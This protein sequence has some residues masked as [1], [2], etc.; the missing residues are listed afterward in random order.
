MTKAYP[1]PIE[2]NVMSSFPGNQSGPS[3]VISLSQIVRTIR[4]NL[5]LLMFVVVTIFSII[6]F[7]T[8]Q[9][10]PIYQASA[11]VI[12][13]QRENAVLD[14]GVL[15]GLPA[16]PGVFETELEI[17][18]SPVLLQRVVRKLELQQ[19]AEFNP[20]LYVP[21]PMEEFQAQVRGVISSLIPK[22]EEEVVK[23]EK[24]LTEE[25]KAEAIIVN[26]AKILGG[27]VKAERDGR[28]FVFYVTASSVDAERAAS[29]ANAV[30]DQYLVDQLD[31]RFEETRRTNE[32]LDDQLTDLRT[33]LN[34]AERAVEAYRSSQGLLS[35]SG[36]TLTE[37]QIADIQAQK[38]AQDAEYSE[39]RARLT[40]VRNSLNSGAGAEAMAEALQSD[41][42]RNLRTQQAQITRERADL[43]TKYGPR[44]P[45]VIS[46][47]GEERDLRSQIDAEV[48]RIVSSLE[49]EVSISRRRL[50]S[51]NESLS[52]LRGELVQNNQATIKLRELE[53]NAEASRTLYEQILAQ[54][55]E[56]NQQESIENVDARIL[57]K[58]DVPMSPALPRK[59]VNF[60]LGLFLGLAVAGGIVLVMELLDNRVSSGEEIEERNGVPFL[61]NV[62][63]LP[64][65]IGSKVQPG[66]Y[67][68]E[69]PMSAFAESMRNLRASVKFANIDSPAKLVTVTSS[70]PAEGKTSL[71]LSLARMSAMTGSRTLVI[72]GDF[73]RHQLTETSGLKPKIGLVEYLLG[74]AELKE[75]I[76]KDT[77]TE[78]DILPLTSSRKTTRDVFGSKTFDAM[79]ERLKVDYDLIV[80]DTAPILL[81]AETRV[82]AAKSDQVL[83]AA[84]WRR[85]SR[86]ALA[87]TLGV[88]REFNANIAGVALTFVDLKRL[89]KHSGAALSNYKA[90]SKYYINN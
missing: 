31:T 24:I 80:V 67:L 38:I 71:S 68:I 4:R 29:I 77:E 13:D 57:A 82:I 69:H 48:R 10:T 61:G 40:A 89:S 27:S 60:A 66:K 33:E 58:A 59:T 16:A 3:Q 83:V 64:S 8:M 36:Q 52:N 49:S 7:L 43:E 9:M 34:S 62:P 70:F 47:V 19:Y 37:Q 2:S 39:R 72:D 18:T 65:G 53:R 21:T 35:A 76:Q 86:A 78:L 84:R 42:I 51:L 74:E 44:H 54:F 73:R 1:Y 75:V 79:I 32:W 41:V 85:T 28:K 26:A 20:A 88:L 25:E 81:M 87:Q 46:I 56:T 14:V 11:K 55:M 63:L 12:V 45:D 17:I 15:S 6:A 30:A 90:Y 22:G 50:D 5:L 23:E